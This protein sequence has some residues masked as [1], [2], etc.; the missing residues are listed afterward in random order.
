MSPTVFHAHP[1]PITDYRTAAAKIA[2]MQAKETATPGFNPDSQT[3]FLTQGQKTR[4]AVLWFHGYTS[5][6]PEFGALAQLCCEKGYNAFVPC[7]PHHGF[8]DRMSPEGSRIKTEELARFSDEMVDLMHG[9]GEEIVVGGLSMGGAM[10]CWVAQ[11][12]ADVDTA[13]IVAP[14]IGAR[15]IPDALIRVVT[16]A[17]QLLPDIHDWWDAQKKEK[18]EGPEYS[19]VYR[20]YHSLGQIM[21]L[22]FQVF[23]DAATQ[24]PKAKQIWMVTNEHDDAVSNP[25]ANRLAAIWR[26][27][28]AKDVQTFC[29]PDALGIPH[30]CIAVDDPHANTEPV[31]KELMRMVG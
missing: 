14:F 4:R 7:I 5:A 24:P 28:G 8:K 11:E 6:P 1:Q 22:G 19:Y 25:M 21:K 31:Y 17:T 3:I 15:I 20:S 12:R 2:A 18:I 23:D 27:S 13:V 10:T 29:F 26:K 16:T 9:L 30:G